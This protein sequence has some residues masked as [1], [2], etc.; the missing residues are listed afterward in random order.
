MKKTIQ[1]NEYEL[2]NIINKVLNEQTKSTTTTS[3]AKAKDCG[4]NQ[5]PCG[6]GC[7]TNGGSGYNTMCVNGMCRDYSVS[8]PTK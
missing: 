8:N 3:P 5:F 7:C 4:Y 1:L 2:I 6:G